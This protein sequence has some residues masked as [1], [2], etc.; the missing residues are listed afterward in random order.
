[1]NS[2]FE[3]DFWLDQWHG[4]KREDTY[5]VHRGFSTVAYW[6]QAAPTYNKVRDEKHSRKLE[7]TLALF[8]QKGLLFKGMTVL[9]IGCG[10]GYLATEFARH[11]ARVTAIDFSKGMLHRFRRELPSELEGQVDIIHRDWNELDITGLGWEKRFDLVIAFMSP[12]VSTPASFFK[13]ISL[14]R[15]G[16]AM[17][18]WSARRQ[19]PVLEA[20]WQKIMK[21]P[22]ADK[23]QSILYKIN[24]LFSMGTF[25]DIMFDTIE[26]DQTVGFED[27]LNSQLAFFEKVSDLSSKAL[28]SV[29]RQYLE[30][31]AVEGKIIRKH[32]GTTAT[33]VWN[34]EP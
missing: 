32:K 22:L 18:G 27:E 29:I 11:G 20:L 1:M 7:K 10:T 16:C 25:P 30:S 17:R 24:L 6:D 34:I 26:W 15:D 12:A 13:M 5:N 31:I 23:P 3:K 8:K 4:D 33:A 19:N 14:S 28:E 2:I 21:R 9:D